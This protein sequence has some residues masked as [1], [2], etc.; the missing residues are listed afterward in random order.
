MGSYFSR[1]G[2]DYFPAG[3]TY[4]CQVCSMGIPNNVEDLQHHLQKYSSK[5][6]VA[7]P[8]QPIQFPSGTEVFVRKTV[9]LVDFDTTND[10]L[11]EQLQRLHRVKAPISMVESGPAANQI[12]DLRGNVFT[13]QELEVVTR[14]AS[15]LEKKGTNTKRPE[16]KG[17]TRM[18]LYGMKSKYGDTGW[19][20]HPRQECYNLSEDFARYVCGILKR[21]YGK[22]FQ[23]LESIPTAEGFLADDAR[24][25]GGPFS[26]LCTSRDFNCRPHK[27]EDDYGYGFIFWLREG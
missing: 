10:A 6:Q 20:V 16:S 27:D 17:S 4:Y 11:N 7:A 2:L 24:I 12:F 18:C 26:S 8:V 1:Q 23:H 13:P 14:M 22:L 9:K 5:H 3:T 19:Y 15:Y 21:S 25:G